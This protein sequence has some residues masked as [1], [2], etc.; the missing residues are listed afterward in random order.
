M[1]T[2]SDPLAAMGRPRPKEKRWLPFLWSSVNHP[3]RNILGTLGARRPSVSAHCIFYD[4]INDIAVLGSP[5]DYEFGGNEMAKAF[6]ELIG[7]V[8][9]LKVGDLSEFAEPVD[10]EWQEV[11]VSVL[12]LKDELISCSAQFSDALF[13]SRGVPTMLGLSVS[14][15]GRSDDEWPP[16]NPFPA[17]YGDGFG[18]LHGSPI[19]APDG[20]VVGVLNGMLYGARLSQHLPSWFWQELKSASTDHDELD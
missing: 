5:R 16:Y 6:E 7:S 3:C 12:S 1:T 18:E 10:D 20:T 2:M 15:K 11:T 19:L 14:R 17:H 13:G 9:I 8:S 4:T